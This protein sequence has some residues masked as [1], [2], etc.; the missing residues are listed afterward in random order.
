MDYEALFAEQL[1]GLR[2]AGNYRVFAEL[3]RQAGQLPAGQALDRGR[4]A[5]RHGLVLQRLSRHGPAPQ[6]ARRD[7][8]DARS[9]RRRRGRHAQ[10]L[11]HQPPARPARSRT[12]R[13]A[14][15]GSRAD[16]HLGVCLE[17]GG[18]VDAGVAAARLRRAVRRAQPCLDDRGHPPQPRQVQALAAQRRRAP[19]RAA[20][21]GRTRPRQA[22]RVRKRLFDG[23]RHRPDRR[24][25]R[26]LREARRADLYRR[27]PC[28]SAF[29]ARA[30]A[31]SPSARG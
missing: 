1:D 8:R 28:A 11:R 16:L 13:S 26:R 2:E 31:A 18:A 20:V 4:H 23:R 22:G 24:D 27:G 6:G 7:A 21:A 17:L 30:A 29:T 15:Q 10:H 12:R 5:G 25:P 9:V 14:R 3:E 19:R